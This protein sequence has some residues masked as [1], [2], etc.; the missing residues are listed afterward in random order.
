MLLPCMPRAAKSR[1]LGVG[2]GGVL[3][4][5]LLEASRLCE[6]GREKWKK[7][8][9]LKKYKRKGNGTERQREQKV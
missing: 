2:R 9:S 6:W 5:P 8:I 1:A 3:P 7:G 4:L